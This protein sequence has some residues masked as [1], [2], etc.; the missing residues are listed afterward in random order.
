MLPTFPSR[1]WFTIGLPKVFSLAAWSPQIQTGF[2]VSRP[3]Q[4][5]VSK[6]TRCLYG[7]VTLCDRTFQNV[8]VPVWFFLTGPTTPAAPQRH[9]FRL[10]PF[11]SPLLWESI[12]LSLPA[13]TKMFQFPALALP[14]QCQAFNLTGSPIRTSPDQVLFADPRSLS[15]LTTSFIAF[16]SLGIHRTLL[17]SFSE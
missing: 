5:P 16:G 11:R 3:T 15:Q 12:F 8:P 4:V 10:F 14:K 13:G 9:R 1:Y 2:H 7:I 17:F 6:H